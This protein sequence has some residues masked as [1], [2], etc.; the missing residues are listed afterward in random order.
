RR[1][2]R[3]LPGL[4]ADAQ[5]R[6]PDRAGRAHAAPDDVDGGLGRARTAR[7]GRRALRTGRRFRQS[8]GRGRVSAASTAPAPVHSPNDTATTAMPRPAFVPISSEPAVAHAEPETT[9]SRGP[10]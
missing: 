2:R 10:R 6:R 3:R 5:G 7:A 1:L 4:H 9:T 8:G